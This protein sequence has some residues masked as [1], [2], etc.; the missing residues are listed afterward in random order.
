MKSSETRNNGKEVSENT[1]RDK[2][3]AVEQVVQEEKRRI[4]CAMDVIIVN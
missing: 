4:D 1:D 3:R 2:T